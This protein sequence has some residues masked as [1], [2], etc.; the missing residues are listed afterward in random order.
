MNKNEMSGREIPSRRP[1]FSDA[2]RTKDNQNVFNPGQHKRRSTMQKAIMTALFL[3]TVA[4][5]VFVGATLASLTT[6]YFPSSVDF[7]PPSVAAGKILTALYLLLVIAGLSIYVYDKLQP[8]VLHLLVTRK[9][10]P[11]QKDVLPAE[12]SFPD[13][14]CAEQALNPAT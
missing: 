13:N 9:K 5:A 11:A 14:N 4:M 3:L 7:A 1:G 12:D 10:P 8:L 2:A 6:A